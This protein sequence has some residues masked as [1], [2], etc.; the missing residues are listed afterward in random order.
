MNKLSKFLTAVL[1]VFTANSAIANDKVITFNQLPSKAQKFIKTFFSQADILTVT[2][3]TEYLVQKEYTVILNDGSKI[4]FDSNG[5]WEKVDAHTKSMPVK[6]VPGSILSH[7]KKS[8]P[9]TFVKEIKK[10]TNKY[11]VEISNGLELEFNRK[12][13]FIRIDD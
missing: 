8:F 9:N 7:V 12:G 3:E 13:E 6:I 11:E 4:E 1:I 10:S 2:E 5:E